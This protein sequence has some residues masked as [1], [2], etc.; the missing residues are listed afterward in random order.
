MVE[1]VDPLILG[2]KLMEVCDCRCTENGFSEIPDAVAA[3]FGEP[4]MAGGDA[5]RL[6]VTL[7]Q[8]SVIRLERDAQI[9]IPMYDYCVP[10][11]ECTAGNGNCGPRVE[12]P[13][14]LFEK[15]QFPI[16]QFVPKGSGRDRGEE[17][18][19]CGC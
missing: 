3:Y 12:D 14:E 5:H 18:S 6:F 16:H 4:L 9:L 7:G 11:K 10:E 13:C 1:A 15:I 2:M 19:G 8:F 17:R